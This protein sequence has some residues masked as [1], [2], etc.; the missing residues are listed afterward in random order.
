MGE[1]TIVIVIYPFALATIK[2]EILK[3]TF[4]IFG[5]SRWAKLVIFDYGINII[6]ILRAWPDT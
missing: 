2:Y 3:H 4:L 6:H 5:S 1:N